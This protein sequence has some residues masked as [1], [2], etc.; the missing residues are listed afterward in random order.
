MYLPTKNQ[1]YIFDEQMWVIVVQ[2]M[3]YNWSELWLFELEI[4]F[5]VGSS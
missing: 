5:S 1:E 4:A 2:I 3:E